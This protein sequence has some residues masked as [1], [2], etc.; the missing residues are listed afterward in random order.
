MH[1]RTGFDSAP[2]T[3]LESD[4]LGLDLFDLRT[5]PGFQQAWDYLRGKVREFYTLPARIGAIKQRAATLLAVARQKGASTAGAEVQAIL[6]GTSEVEA[7]HRQTAA[8]VSEAMSGAT[9]A[10]LGVI[11]WLAISA[12]M[13]AAA[14]IKW[15]LDRVKRDEHTLDMIE[16][17]LL[18]PAEAA[19]LKSDGL[20]PAWGLQLGKY[21]LPLGIGAAAW[22]LLRGRR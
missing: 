12:I 16:Q 15:L 6:D 8:K 10:G 7:K 19:A 9:E 1:Y 14:G 13:T 18:S 2:Y 22:F 5:W 11:P 4:G 3:G 21:A 17:G 20:L